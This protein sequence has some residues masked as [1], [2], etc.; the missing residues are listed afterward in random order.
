MTETPDRTE[1]IFAAAVVLPP[2]ERV[3]YVEQ[4]CADSPELRGRLDALLRA[5]VVN[6]KDIG[7]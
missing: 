5:E 1:S 6:R 2:G 7:M 3:A 4:A